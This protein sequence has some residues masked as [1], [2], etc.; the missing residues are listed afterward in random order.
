MDSGWEEKREKEK[1][2][3][4][5]GETGGEHHWIFY[6]FFFLL[7]NTGIEIFDILSIRPTLYI[8]IIYIHTNN[9]WHL[10]ISADFFFSVPPTLGRLRTSVKSAETHQETLPGKR[11]SHRRL[12]FCSDIGRIGQ[13]PKKGLEL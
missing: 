8:Y 12:F 3:M 4:E 10:A 13:Q 9:S 11:R 7:L 6:V 1:R 2:R 5:I